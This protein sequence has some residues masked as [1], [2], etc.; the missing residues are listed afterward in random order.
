MYN[1]SQIWHGIE[2]SWT[3]SQN[4]QWS[5]VKYD[6]VF[7]QIE[8]VVKMANDFWS[9]MTWSITLCIYLLPI[10]P[11]IYLVNY[12]STYTHPPTHP[13][14]HLSTY[15]FLTTYLHTC[16]YFSPLYD[17]FTYL[18]TYLH[19]IYFPIHPFTYQILSIRRNN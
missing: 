7:I 17:L 3:C 12:L 8:H 11:P 18:P 5:L 6:M 9:N 1:F 16:I 15:T 14:T 13:P 2:S 4:G 10:H 19:I